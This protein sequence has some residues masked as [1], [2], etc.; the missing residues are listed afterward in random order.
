MAVPYYVFEFD[1]DDAFVMVQEMG[2]ASVPSACATSAS[3]GN[4]ASAKRT[5]PLASTPFLT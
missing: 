2:A 1:P 3:V 4:D 5:T